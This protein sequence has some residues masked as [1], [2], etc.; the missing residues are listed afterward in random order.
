MTR[1]PGST[2]HTAGVLV[3]ECREGEPPPAVVRLF[4]S[5]ENNGPVYDTGAQARKSY[6][7]ARRFLGAE[8]ANRHSRQYCASSGPPQKTDK[9]IF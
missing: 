3:S 2:S 8:R 6:S 9:A 5:A 4:I 1:G 7:L